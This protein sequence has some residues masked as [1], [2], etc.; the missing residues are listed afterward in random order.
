MKTKLILRQSF[1]S[2]GF[3]LVSKSRI[4]SAFAMVIGVVAFIA[5]AVAIAIGYIVLVS[6]VNAA[7]TASTGLSSVQSVN[8][9][10]I[11]TSVTG[12]FLLLTVLP[13]VL[14]ASLII[15][16]LFLFMQFGQRSG[17]GGEM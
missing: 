11:G 12:A 8:L 9:L 5:V 16:A 17:A 14:A 3:R 10:S 2:L 7:Q 1:E 13:V 15:G 6:T 4:G